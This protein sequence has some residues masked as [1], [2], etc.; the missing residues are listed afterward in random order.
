MVTFYLFG[1]VTN[2]D[3]VY[4]KQPVLLVYKENEE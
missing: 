4:Y 2:M 1:F 3:V